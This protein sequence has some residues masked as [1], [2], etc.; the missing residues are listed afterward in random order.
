MERLIHKQ[1]LFSE[2][3]VAQFFFMGVGGLSVMF[4][5]TESPFPPPPPL[6]CRLHK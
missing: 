1:M 2:G 5:V 4:V 6:V 3:R